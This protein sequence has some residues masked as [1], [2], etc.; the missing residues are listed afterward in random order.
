VVNN[1]STLHIACHTL[2]LTMECRHELALLRGLQ[3]LD[4]HLMLTKNLQYHLGSL[5]H[6]LQ[7][8]LDSLLRQSTKS[9]CV[10]YISQ[11]FF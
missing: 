5:Q 10:A 3:A 9:G 2:C 11:E 8:L 7:T 6:H 4:E 1:Y